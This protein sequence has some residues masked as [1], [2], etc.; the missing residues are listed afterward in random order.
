MGGYE[1]CCYNWNE[2]AALIAAG[3]EDFTQFS[4]NPHTVFTDK[5]YNR[6]RTKERE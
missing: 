5:L 2:T 3:L 1:S 6:Y 4:H